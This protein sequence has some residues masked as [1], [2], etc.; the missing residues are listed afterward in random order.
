MDIGDYIRTVPDFPKKGIQ[1]KDITTL[2]QNE[3]AFKYVIDVLKERYTGQ[4]VDA[5]IGADA[6]GFIFGSA[7]CYAMDMPLVLVRKKGKLPHETI[8]EEY[9]LEYGT[10]ALEIHVDA[11]KPKDRVVLVDD[12]L[13]TGGTMYAAATLVEKLKAEVVE[14]AF[15]VELPLLKGR[16]RLDKYPVHSLVQFM[17][18]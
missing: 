10:D 6:R 17:V 8:A 5:I 2:L 7:L 12:L 1:F 11:L 13:A 14:L 18:E 4:K 3:K 15:V 9:E 16:E